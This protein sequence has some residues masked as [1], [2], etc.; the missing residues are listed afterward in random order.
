MD[1]RVTL[2]KE[3]YSTMQKD[4]IKLESNCYGF[5]FLE[6]L[7]SH[8]VK[9]EY[10]ELTSSLIHKYKLVNIP[11]CQIDAFL[12]GHINKYYNACLYFNE[13]ANNIFCFNLDNNFKE[14]N[15]A[16]IP[17]M[18][19]SVDQ[20]TQYLTELGIEPLVIVSGRGYHVWC[21]LDAPINN[22]Q[23]HNFMLKI[24]A[25][26]M[27]ALHTNGYDYHRVKFNMYPNN[28]IINTVSLRFFGS[29]HVKNKIF[30]YV[31]S[32]NSVLEEGESWEYFADYLKNKTI[33]KEQFMLASDKLARYFA[34]LDT[35]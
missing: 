1:S 29:E 31:Y 32:K 11:D 17:E 19:F 30:S 26:T 8:D 24:V 9:L 20:L 22:K 28:E 23:L 18:Q 16:L 3:F 25:R 35:V 13:E 14:N 34:G 33:S 12:Q 21:R 5:E 27:E 15:T 7:L 6:S 10:G 4:K 2:L